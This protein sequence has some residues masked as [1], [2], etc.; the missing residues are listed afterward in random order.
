MNARRAFIRHLQDRFANFLEPC[1]GF[2][3][4]VTTVSSARCAVRNVPPP[5][6]WPR[7]KSRGPNPC[8][9]SRPRTSA[10]ADPAS[11]V[12]FSQCRH[13]TGTFA[14]LRCLAPPMLAT[15]GSCRSSVPASLFLR[16]A[17]NSSPVRHEA[18]A[19][20]DGGFCSERDPNAHLGQAGKIHIRAILIDSV[21]DAI[22]DIIL[23]ALRPRQRRGP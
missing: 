21:D 18:L 12:A 15:Q 2:S 9:R 1:I 3:N 22:I 17:S 11:S 6:S 19:C 10:A 23:T 14:A 16:A 8:N 4:A 7:L 13:N 20:C 5:N